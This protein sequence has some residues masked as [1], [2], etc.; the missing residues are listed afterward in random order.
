V[1]EQLRTALSGVS[2]LI[3]ALKSERRNQKSLKLALDSLKHL[4]AAA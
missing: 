3:S 2:G 4:Q 1:R